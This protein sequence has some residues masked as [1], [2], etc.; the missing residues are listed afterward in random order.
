MTGDS[1]PKHSIPTCSRNAQTSGGRKCSPAVAEA[2]S[3][4]IATSRNGGE[5]P[6]PTPSCFNAF[7]SRY[8]LLQT[9]GAPLST[10]ASVRY[11]ECNQS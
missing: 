3:V 11:L 9:G 10:R 2:L 1:D 4:A 8:A 6:L 5:L 7:V